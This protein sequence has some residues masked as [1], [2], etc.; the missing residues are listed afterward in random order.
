MIFKKMILSRIL[1]NGMKMDIAVVKN[2][3]TYQAALYVNGRHIPGPPLPE[4]L[5]PPKDGLSFWMGN[6]PSVGLSEDEAAR[7]IREVE[8]E[9]GVQKHR[10][11]STK[12]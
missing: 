9:N 7:I 3:D 2:E 6:K 11:A 5:R 4:P 8:L 10:T 12:K 1:S